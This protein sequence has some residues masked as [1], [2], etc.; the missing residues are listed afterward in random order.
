MNLLLDTHTFIWWADEP[1]KLSADALQ[2]LED[3]NNHLSLSLVSVWE[4]QI[5]VQLG[6][7]KLSLPLK[8]LVESQERANELEVLPVTREH[9]FAL[10]NLPFHH[11]D[12]FDRLLIAQG[13][14][15]DATI[16]SADPK[17]SAYPVTLL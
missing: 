17:L 5:K 14:I 10:N 15:E 9:I 2:A 11:K 13:I 3:E 1:E 12:P 7:I 8:Y 6:K 16:V 4:M